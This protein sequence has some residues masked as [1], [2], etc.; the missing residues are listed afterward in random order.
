MWIALDQLPTDTDM[1]HRLVHDMASALDS[2]Q[3]EIE[4][5]RQIIVEFKRARFGRS[6][7]RL[8]PEQASLA[9]EE[10]E[11]DLAVAV[12]ALP[13]VEPSG[14]DKNLLRS[15]DLTSSTSLEVPLEEVDDLFVEV[16]MEAGSVEVVGAGTDG[17][18]GCIRSA[19]R[20]EVEM[21]G[22]G[23]VVKLRRT[24]ERGTHGIGIVRRRENP[25]VA[26]PP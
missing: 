6:A 3:S 22:T 5:L 15:A 8:D 26:G 10:L 24:G 2:R 17:Q 11:T 12:A 13:V 1:L 25:I 16:A 19:R 23:N 14:Q 20:Q 4:R 18:S 21:T 9:L 7:E